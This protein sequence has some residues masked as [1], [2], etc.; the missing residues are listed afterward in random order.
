MNIKLT[1][2]SSTTCNKYDKHQFRLFKFLSLGR[3][4]PRSKEA[5]LTLPYSVDERQGVCHLMDLCIS[6]TIKAFDTKHDPGTECS[7]SIN[8]IFHVL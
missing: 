8:V 6:L 1:P 3:S 7:E 4:F 2:N 5:Q